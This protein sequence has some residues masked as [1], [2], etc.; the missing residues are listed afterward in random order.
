MDRENLK[1]I[2]ITHTDTLVSEITLNFKYMYSL[3]KKASFHPY[4]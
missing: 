2:E 1:Q 4:I 3:P